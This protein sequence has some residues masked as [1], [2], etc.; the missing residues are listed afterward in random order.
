[1]TFHAAFYSIEGNEY[2]IEIKTPGDGSRD[3]QLAGNPITTTVDA[4][5][6]NL[7]EP[8]RCGGA[9]VRLLTMWPIWQLYSGQAKGVS[10]KLWG[11]AGLDWTGYVSPTMYS[12]GYDR[13]LEEIAVDCIDGLAVLKYIPY[14]PDQRKNLTFLEIIRKCLREAE[15]FERLYISTNVQRQSSTTNEGIASILRVSENAFTGDKEDASQPDRDVAWSCYDVL[16]EIMRFLGYT[17]TCQGSNVYCVD[18]DSLKAGDTQYRRYDIDKDD[19]EGTLTNIGT[20]TAITGASYAA[21]GAQISLDTIYNKVRVSDEFRSMETMFPHFGD[22]AFEENITRHAEDNWLR[23]V[24]APNAIC[25]TIVQDLGG[26]DGTFQF[27]VDGVVKDLDAHESGS[28]EKWKG[29][30]VLVRFYRSQ[31]FDFHRY[32]RLSHADMTEQFYNQGQACWGRM[33][34][35]FGASYVKMYKKEL[36]ASM[37]LS[38]QAAMR[39]AGNPESSEERWAIVS[40]YLGDLDI[41]KVKFEPMIIFTNPYDPTGNTYRH[42]G[43]SAFNRTGTY[44]VVGGQGADR[45]DCQNFPC[46][47]MRPELPEAVFGGQNV[48]MVLKGTYQQHDQFNHPFPIDNDDN[49]ALKREGDLKNEDEL[50]FWAKLKW[51]DRY[52]SPDGWSPFDSF[53]KVW[54]RKDKGSIHVRTYYGADF[55]LKDNSNAGFIT[56]NDGVYITP[57]SSGNLSGKPEFKIYLNRDSRGHSKR[58]AWGD[59]DEKTKTCANKNEN[60]YDRYYNE[61][62]ILQNLDIAFKAN[63]GGVFDEDELLSDT[64]YVNEVENGSVE[65]MDE[66]KFKVCTY[67]QKNLSY[68]VVDYLDPST[69]RSHYIDKLINRALYPDQKDGMRQE[70]HM[71]YKCV[72][73]YESPRLIF[74]CCLRNTVPTSL[75][76]TFTDTSFS[77]QTFVVIGK[78]TDWKMESVTLKLLEKA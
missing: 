13:E 46:V 44:H 66:I 56:A 8:I 64:V 68:S 1:M 55:T 45:E 33:L 41:D 59:W 70:E 52:L 20:R 74:E 29:Y 71:V 21:N 34:D 22:E 24:Y 78:E 25:G 72:T 40:E 47:T 14:L 48:Y 10:V 77:G 42:V 60:F 65:E 26:K 35:T 63:A 32:H 38:L 18:Y 28:G 5:D 37:L 4:T 58:N 2:R 67:D 11:P 50:F 23:E 51:G 61:V 16:A 57:P 19:T 36:P 12:Q 73:Q 69:G 17:M 54:W 31:I 9:T 7:Y 6:K 62:Q 49:D 3:V 15:C 43:P 76:D 53:F 39:S 27:I 30:L 75:H